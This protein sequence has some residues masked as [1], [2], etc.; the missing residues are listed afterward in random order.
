MTITQLGATT[1]RWQ[2]RFGA[3]TLGLK[4]KCCQNIMQIQSLHTGQRIKKSFYQGEREPEF[5]VINENFFLFNA[6]EKPP[7]NSTEFKAFWD[8]KAQY[9]KKAEPDHFLATHLHYSENS[10]F[11]WVNF[12]MFSSD[13]V[14]VFG[15]PDPGWRKAV[16]EGFQRNFTA[17]PA[18][19]RNIASTS[20]QGYC[21]GGDSAGQGFFLSLI[22]V[23]DK[24]KHEDLIA[25]WKD[26]TYTTLLREKLSQQSI[27]TGDSNL[28]RRWA[29]APR[30][31]FVVRTPA[32]FNNPEDGLKVAEEMNA[33]AEEKDGVKVTIGFYLVEISYMK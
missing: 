29:M 18:G 22:E 27:S 30:F 25:N 3:S 24:S 4:N 17:Y 23:D 26:V 1:L 15:K 12:A 19:Y 20:G 7:M 28:F 6:F 16:G 9:V 8:D 5:K 33:A 10:C 13:D 32:P 11:P 14:I 31:P 21:D 2:L